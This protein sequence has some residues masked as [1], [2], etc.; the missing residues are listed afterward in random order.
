M[1]NKVCLPLT[2]FCNLCLNGADYKSA[3]AGRLESLAEFY[4]KNKTKYPAAAADFFAQ[5]P[6]LQKNNTC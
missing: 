5:H 1:K 4:T 6:Q 2:P 3:P